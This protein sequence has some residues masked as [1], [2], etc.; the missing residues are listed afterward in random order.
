MADEAATPSG[1]E[2]R[3]RAALD[4]TREL[5]IPPLGIN[6]LTGVEGTTTWG[7]IFKPS[8]YSRWSID[9]VSSD[10]EI[11]WMPLGVNKL[12]T[13]AIAAVTS[14][15]ISPII[16]KTSLFLNAQV[17]L[18]SLCA[19][20]H[21]YQEATGGAIVDL[22]GGFTTTGICDI[23]SW[24]GTLIL[25]SDSVAQK[26]YSW[27]GS[28]LVTVFSTQPVNYI[29][30][31]S[32]RL[33]MAKGS[34]IQWTNA[35]TYNSLAGDSGSYIVTDSACANPVIGMLD[36]PAGLDI[37]ASNWSKLITNLV[38]T[39]I[40]AVL[41]FQQNT[42]KSNVG[43]IN[44]WSVGLIGDM[45]YF[46]NV[47]G[48]FRLDGAFPTQISSPALDGFFANLDPI[49]SSFSFAY[50]VINSKRCAFWQVYYLGDTQQPAGSTVLGYVLD[51]NLWFRYRQNV[52][53]WITGI[54]S[55]AITNNVPTVW[56]SD[57]TNT[58]LCFSSTSTTLTSTWNS[59]LWDF[60]SPLDY[61]SVLAVAILFIVTGTTTITVRQL[62]E[63]NTIQYTP[64]SQTFSPAIGQWQNNVGTLGNWINNASTQG[65][66]TGSSAQA[67]AL[68]Q[69]DGLGRCR[70]FGLNVVVLGAQT[71][72]VSVA[73]S[74]KRT[75]AGKGS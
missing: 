74:Y 36:T 43:P 65:S 52:I 34:V 73:I 9:N 59:R 4:E 64:P 10:D 54:V 72:L 70:Q 66:W 41:T 58:F 42:F 44:K 1:S 15:L 6:G 25:I 39:G 12:Q 55:T 69:S 32:G 14:T 20:G 46:A 28:A 49:Q 48:V 26:I 29:C 21:I 2:N 31:F 19:N 62:D 23:T 22:G 8:Q 67:Y 47:Y 38:S 27:N 35:N 60:G 57:G 56:G 24:Q 68:Y 61:D 50:G 16:W 51:T 18:Y 7:G 63:S 11:N 33:W 71:T 37:F 75:L 17:F 5:L 13:P 3:A 45:V 40:P 53:S 30:V